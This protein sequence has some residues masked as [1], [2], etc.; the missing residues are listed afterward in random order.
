MK[1]NN[2]NLK[3]LLLKAVQI[4]PVI[5]TVSMIIFCVAFIVKNDISITNLDNLA[6]YFSGGVITVSL[7]MILFNVVKSFALIITPVYLYAL[8]GL[9]YEN[10]WLAVAVNFVGTF[11]SLILIYYLGRFMGMEVVNKLKKRFKA[12]QKLENFTGENAFA[13]VFVCKVGAILPSDLN[14]LVFGAMNLPFMPYFIASNIS[15]LILNVSWTLF[16]A[17]G[18]FTDPKSYLYILPAFIMAFAGTFYMSAK[19]KKKSSESKNENQ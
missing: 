7:M 6:V 15:L 5:F 4:I 11:I 17:K 3:D 18:D 19:E 2:S 10:I 9:I 12:I 1:K 14:S 16:T 13:V 8:S